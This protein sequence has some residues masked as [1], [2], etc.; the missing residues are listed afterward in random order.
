LT[1]RIESFI[2]AVTRKT[3]EHHNKRRE[4][5]MVAQGPA[6]PWGNKMCEERSKK[7]GGLLQSR[8]VRRQTKVKGE[9]G[10]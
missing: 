4:L 7:G 5:G 8:S 3:T 9:P 10:S 1:K 6:S 2:K